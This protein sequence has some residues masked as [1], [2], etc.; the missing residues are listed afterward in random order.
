MYTNLVLSGGALRGV[1]LLG[2]IKYLEELDYIKYIK[3]YI[4]TSAGAIICFFIILGYNSNEI[5]DIIIKE[6]N[7][8]VDLDFENIPN[9]L[10]DYGIDDC[11]KNKEVFTKY[12]KLKTDL[13]DITFIDFTKK[14]GLN[15][16]I[17]GSNLT[18]HN[19]DYFNVDNTPNMSII[20]ALLITSCL[21]LIYKPIKY[22]EC[23]YIDGGIYNN[24]A[25]DY[26]EK[27][28]NETLGI[29]VNSYFSRKNN[30]FVD[31]F[32]N[33][34]Y[35]IMDKLTYDNLNNNKNYNIY[36]IY[37]D[38]NMEDDIKFSLTDLKIEINIDKINYNFDYG[39]N[40]F[41]KKFKIDF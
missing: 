33:I 9:F 30:N 2:A 7:T 20:N 12:L 25:I 37:F 27:N 5:I 35:S 14:F 8:M 28:K 23:I 26:F 6:I 24:F 1:G 31:Y 11:K 34:I 32:N 3:N 21:P 29:N 22:N 41:K 16:I 18:T 4:G 13:E 39:Y 15:L 38:K 40:D 36:N 10:D 19:L 17:T